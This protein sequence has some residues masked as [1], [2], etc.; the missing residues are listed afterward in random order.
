MTT[1]ISICLTNSS[2][3]WIARNSDGETRLI[4]GGGRVG[5][6]TYSG[7][8]VYRSLKKS[9]LKEI[10]NGKENYEYAFPAC[11]AAPNH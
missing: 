3:V 7:I 5:G 4:N 11:L 9:I 10:N 1:F 6:E 2:A 8:H